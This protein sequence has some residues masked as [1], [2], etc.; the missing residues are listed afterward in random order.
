MDQSIPF[1]PGVIFFDI[2]KSFDED[3]SN[4]NYFSTGFVLGPFIIP[5]YQSWGSEKYPNNLNW[6]GERI[7]LKSLKFSLIFSAKDKQKSL[8]LRG[9]LK[10]FAH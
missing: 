7:R 6:L 5:L 10:S 2:A 4:P 9:L 8:A 1:V 3:L